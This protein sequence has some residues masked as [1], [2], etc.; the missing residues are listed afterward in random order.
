[1]YGTIHDVINR[2]GKKIPLIDDPSST[3][4]TINQNRYSDSEKFCIC[5]MGQKDHRKAG[6]EK[7]KYLE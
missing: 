3:I 7:P 1:M 2:N 5:H 4:S 6:S